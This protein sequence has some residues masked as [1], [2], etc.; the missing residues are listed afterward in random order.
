MNVVLRA[1]LLALIPIAVGACASPQRALAL[2][3]TTSVANSGLLDVLL[4][5][6]E[7]ESGVAAR[8]HLVGSGRALAMLA[9]GDADVAITHAPAAEETALRAHPAWRYTKVMFN[10][11]VIV[12][13]GADPARVR[14]ADSAGAAMLK[15]ATARVRFIS[16]GDGSGTHEREQAL[17]KEAGAAPEGALLVAAGSG[18]GATLRIASTMDAYTLTD[19]AT[20]MQQETRLAILFDGG[21]SLVN[22]YAVSFDTGRAT[23]PAAQRFAT[24]LADGA[25]RTLIEEF[26]VGPTR[27]VAFLPWPHGRPRN[28][29]AALPR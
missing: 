14:A 5:A 9:A 6:Y 29:P 23:A 16:R 20:F 12:G 15:I 26:R 13:P 21:S 22:T 4:A 27:T 17:W 24:W 11:F 18:M 7:R 1:A 10:D 8:A 28:D 3:T 2:A 25:G 19:R